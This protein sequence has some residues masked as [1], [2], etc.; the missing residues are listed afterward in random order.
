MYPKNDDNFFNVIDKIITSIIN[1]IFMVCPL[2]VSREFTKL[3]DFQTNFKYCENF[4]IFKRIFK[5]QNNFQNYV[6]SKI[7]GFSNEFSKLF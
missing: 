7:M 6:I 1:V 3:W 2:S 5:I 4:K